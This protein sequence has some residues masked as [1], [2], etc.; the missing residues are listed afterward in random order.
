MDGLSKKQK[1]EEEDEKKKLEEQLKVPFLY[2]VCPFLHIM[3]RDRVLNISPCALSFHLSTES[4]PADLGTQGQA[5]EVLLNQRH[6]GAADCKWPGG[7][8]R[9]VQCKRTLSHFILFQTVKLQETT[10]KKYIYITT[11]SH[12]HIL[13]FSC[14]QKSGILIECVQKYFTACR[15]NLL[16]SLFC[17]LYS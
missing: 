5:E 12:I 2:T 16:P 13:K 6:E 7:A 15:R 1:K 17:V 9:R 3:F 11:A 10:V 4:K 14:V 8:L